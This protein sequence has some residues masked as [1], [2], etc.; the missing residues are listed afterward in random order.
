M[1]TSRDTTAEQVTAML[2]A[3][4]AHT[5]TTTRDAAAGFIMPLVAAGL[6]VIPLKPGDKAPR[7]TGWQRAV[8][9]PEAWSECLDDVFRD[10]TAGSPA[11][12]VGMRAGNRLIVADADTPDQVAALD[13]FLAARG[14]PDAGPT[15]ATPGTVDRQHKDG[16]HWWFLL[17]DNYAVHAGLPAVLTVDAEGRTGT[18]VQGPTFD[19]FLYSKQ[20]AIP[21]TQRDA[22]A[23]ALVGEVYDLPEAVCSWLTAE[24]EAAAERKQEQATRRAALAGDTESRHP[25]LEAWEERTPWADILEPA[26][27]AETGADAACGCTQWRHPEASSAKSSTAHDCQRGTYLEVWSTSSPVLEAGPHSK[28]AAFAA[29][30]HGGDFAAAYGA[31]GIPAQGQ[32]DTRSLL[33]L[34]SAATTPEEPS[35]MTVASSQETAGQLADRLAAAVALRSGSTAAATIVAQLG[36]DGV[37]QR[38]DSLLALGAEGLE[39]L[40]RALGRERAEVLRMDLGRTASRIKRTDRMMTD[41]DLDAAYDAEEREPVHGGLFYAQSLHLLAAPGGAGKTWLTLAAAIPPAW[42]LPSERAQDTRWGIY[43]DADGNGAQGLLTRAAQLGADRERVEHG[44]L[45]VVSLPSLATRRGVSQTAALAGVI[46]DLVQADPL[47]QVVIVDSLTQLLA[48]ADGDSNSDTA[49]T[50]ALRQF[51]EL[52]EL[53]CVVVV[54]HVGHEASERPRGSSAKGQAVDVVLTM[55]PMEPDADRYPDTEMS[56]RVSIAKDRHNGIKTT[57]CAPG[58]RATAGVWTLDRTG[59]TVTVG[60]RNVRE[61]PGL[62]SRIIPAKVSAEKRE[63]EAAKADRE[64]AESA[65][66]RVAEV[67]RKAG[68]EVASYKAL[69]SALR[70]DGDGMTKAAAE[71]AIETAVEAGAVDRRKTGRSTVYALM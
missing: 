12:G 71:A 69:V 22:G 5:L 29:L 36:P 55:R 49:V 26:G 68:G 65:P 21:P 1:S 6:P 11:L 52:S 4:D 40:A 10:H 15:V 61:L 44:D 33:A 7:M 70:E 47:P 50:A 66:I 63:R 42:P 59:A 64:A 39:Q 38:W 18:E 35:A 67:I 37:R 43:I 56:A 14:L 9:T 54:D 8:I 28:I 48:L 24:G 25:G 27:W 53:T 32:I 41:E 51:R 45:E 19:M 2:A 58:D 20:A 62:V 16:G 3:G 46:A 13:A 34:P 17:P 23:Y 30:H 57:L 60:K 31:A